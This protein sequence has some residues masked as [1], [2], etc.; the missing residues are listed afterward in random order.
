MERE[1]ERHTD[2]F[3]QMVTADGDETS[4]SVTQRA[5]N[6]RLMALHHYVVNCRE[7]HVSSDVFLV[8]GE[9]PNDEG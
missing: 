8:D 9:L 6:Y 3:P 1:C 2:A 4:S 7:V 5:V